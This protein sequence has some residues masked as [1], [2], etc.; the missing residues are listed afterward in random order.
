MGRDE[1]VNEPNGPHGPLGHPCPECGAPRA[2]D[3]TPSCACARLT[4][5]AVRDTRTAEVAAAEDF[6]P[7]RVRPYVEYGRLGEP[8]EPGGPGGPSGPGGAPAERTMPLRAVP[9]APVGPARRIWSC[10]RR[11]RPPGT[12]RPSRAG[13]ADGRCCWWRRGRGRW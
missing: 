12:P 4:S 2:A 1:H 7:L 5:D 11:V 9:A 13:G 8:G 3:H 6:D 10:S